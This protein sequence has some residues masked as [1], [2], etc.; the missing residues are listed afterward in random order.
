MGFGRWPLRIVRGAGT[1]LYIFIDS[2]TNETT[3]K[4]I[5]TTVGEFAK[6]RYLEYYIAGGGGAGGRGTGTL[7]NN[8]RRFTLFNSHLSKTFGTSLGNKIAFFTNNY[9]NIYTVNNANYIDISNSRISINVPNRGANCTMTSSNNK[10]FIAGGTF[11]DNN[12]NN[13]FV[14]AIDIY[15]VTSANISNSKVTANLSI[16]RDIL[17]SVASD[18]KK[19]FFAGGS[20]GVNLNRVDIFDATAANINNSRTLAYL[21]SAR[22]DMTA[23][24]VNN[25]VFF[26]GGFTTS[27]TATTTI[28]M[29]DATAADISN[30]RTI[31][32]LISTRGRLTSTSANNKVFFAG[33]YSGATANAVSTVDIFDTT[34]AN[35]QASR[36]TINL[37]Y[38]FYDLCSISLGNFVFFGCGRTPFQALDA[39]DRF[40][41]SQ[42]TATDINNSKK[43]IDIGALALENNAYLGTAYVSNLNLIFFAGI[44]NFIQYFDG[45]N[46]DNLTGGG[47]GGSGFQKGYISITN[48]D[49]SKNYRLASNPPASEIKYDLRGNN[50]I[51]SIE[52]I[53]GA[54][55]NVGDVSGQTTIITLKSNGTFVNSFQATGGFSGIDGEN[56]IAGSGG[57]GF[58]GGGGGAGGIDASDT[59]SGG[60]SQATGV[61]YAGSAST[62]TVSGTNTTYTSGAG[63]GPG[64]STAGGGSVSRTPTTIQKASLSLG[65]GGGG[66]N[67]LGSV[68]ASGAVHEPSSAITNS[69]KGT[70]YTSQGGGGGASILGTPG[71]GGKGF[72]ILKFTNTPPT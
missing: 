71:R 27:Q 50:N 63:A 32:T 34:A 52:T 55:A 39:V 5:D 16:G 24:S 67:Y 28:D 9:L 46:L 68:P 29:F 56:S 15:D 18:N 62:E 64:S 42:S 17:S 6:Y 20:N 72:A 48:P 25:K 58:F 69:I 30:S 8:L 57:Q 31:L 60:A 23:V 22:R 43:K 1:D 61:G 7:S 19:V 26:A 54:G 11:V 3:Y 35:I 14:D 12:N 51:S 44:N 2:A 45:K 59:A 38:K 13:V 53:I 36:I 10:I 65:G 47:G 40:D 41:A 21:S 37:T 4:F 33:G 49:N 66:G 70:D